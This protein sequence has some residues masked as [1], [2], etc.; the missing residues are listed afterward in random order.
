MMP[1]F[2]KYIQGIFHGLSSA[3]RHFPTMHEAAYPFHM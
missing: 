2:R 1:G 3:I